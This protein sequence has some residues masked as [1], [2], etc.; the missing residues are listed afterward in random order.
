[1]ATPEVI[2][3]TLL[4]IDRAC[5]LYEFNK[6]R[7]FSLVVMV[8][9]QLSLKLKNTTCLALDKI[10]E[11]LGL[12]VMPEEIMAAEQFIVELLNFDIAFMTP[13]E[14]SFVLLQNFLK[15]SSLGRGQ[16]QQLKEIQFRILLGTFNQNPKS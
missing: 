7:G 16:I 12:T 3:H 8:C 11:C 10:S 6:P 15:V 5:C 9:F 14:A 2:E 13:F 1:M 4:L